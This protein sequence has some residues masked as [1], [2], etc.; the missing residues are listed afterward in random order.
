LVTELVPMLSYSVTYPRHTQTFVQIHVPLS[1]AAAPPP[2]SQASP[3]VL[4]NYGKRRPT[5]IS[6]SHAVYVSDP[7]TNDEELV[8]S[9][10]SGLLSS[11]L[12]CKSARFGLNIVVSK[13]KTGV[14]ESY[15]DP[16]VYTFTS[17][18][19]TLHSLKSHNI[20]DDRL[21]LHRH[22]SEALTVT[23]GHFVRGCSLFS[24]V[25]YTTAYDDAEPWDA[26]LETLVLSVGTWAVMD[27]MAKIKKRKEAEEHAIRERER[28]KYA[29]STA[30]VVGATA[31]TVNL[32]TA[33]R[34]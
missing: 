32:L 18:N 11:D 24:L 10:E 9:I 14:F 5:G 15:N 25:L 28:R 3:A 23:I 8:W 13:Q 30:L 6:L 2:A 21:T 7:A 20:D 22:Y 16:I 31:G 26:V 33:K 17:P 34:R 1:S 29:M 12:F 4:L 27:S 19:G